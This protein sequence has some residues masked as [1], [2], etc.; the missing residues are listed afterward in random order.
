MWIHK[1]LILVLFC[2]TIVPAVAQ[3][4]RSRCIEQPLIR[5]TRKSLTVHATQSTVP[6]KYLMRASTNVSL[7]QSL[8]YFP[9]GSEFE[10]Y[11]Y[12]DNRLQ[13]SSG[14][15]QRLV[16]NP[17]YYGSALNQYEIIWFDYECG[18]NQTRSHQSSHYGR[19]IQQTIRHT[20]I[21][22]PSLI[23]TCTAGN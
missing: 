13:C 23:P 11:A 10:A 6:C 9:E 1:V 12:I 5:F 21:H 8:L 22:S 20:N 17:Q 16:S 3:S 7:C 18:A 19:V 14:H 15:C 4:S 2:L